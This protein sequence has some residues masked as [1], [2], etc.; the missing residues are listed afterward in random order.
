M[1]ELQL[2]GYT[3]ELDHLVLDLVDGGAGRYRLVVDADLFATL[4]ELREQRRARGLPVGDLVEFAEEL[5]VPADR[6]Q[7]I[8]DEDAEAAAAQGH[9]SA[10]S[11]LAEHRVAAADDEVDEDTDD[12]G[13]APVEAP[14]TTV[15]EPT[16]VE[17]WRLEDDHDQAGD[18]PVVLSLLAGHDPEESSV[19]LVSRPGDASD[20]AR[21]DDAVPAWVDNG[22]AP[23]A[24]PPPAPEPDPEPAPEPQPEPE[25]EPEPEPEVEPVA[26]P[27]APLP[28]QPVPRSTVEPGTP[29]RPQPTLSPAEIQ[30]RLRSGRSVRAVARAAGVDEERIRRWEVPIVAERARVLQQAHALR[31]ER[32]RLGRS[33]QPLGEAVR[34]N[35]ANRGVA[36]E[37]I[38]WETSRRQDG[39]W[40]VCVR[41]VSRGRKRSATW[42]YAP[43]EGELQ[44]ASDTA[45][46]LGFVR[47]R[48]R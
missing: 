35:L 44:A 2:I 41:Y 38:D 29:D 32:P 7:Q 24:S 22:R 26:P 10:G 34:R 46:D 14:V 39:R 25:S 13:D 28:P 16:V 11:A 19:R 47:R 40:R 42:T 36:R 18:E 23:D 30:A 5:G 17:G 33:A 9:V 8:D 12:A 21:G 4:D 6:L 1:I 45:R 48:R 3:A 43:D 15:V 37:T 20:G 31:L 27:L